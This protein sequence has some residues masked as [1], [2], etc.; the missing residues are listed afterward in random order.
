[1]KKIFS[2]LM[3]V[4]IAA[5][6]FTACED[7]PEPYN[8]PYNN[9]TS[10]GEEPIE[11]VEPAGS[12]TLEDP[13]NVARA[14]ELT[15]AMADGESLANVYV[16]G[17]IV[18]ITDMSTSYGNCTYFISD[19]ERGSNR[20]E[21]YRGYGLNGDYFTTGTEIKEGDLVVVKGTMVN[22][23]G[24]TPELTQGSEI[25]SIN[26]EG[27]GSVIPT[28]TP[29]DYGKGTADAPYN[30]AGVQ[31]AGSGTGVY[32]K[33][34][35]VGNVEGQVLSSGAVFG[36][37]GDTQ[38]NILLADS[39]SETDLSN[40]IPVQLPLGDVRTAVNLKDN[41]GNYKKEVTLY[42]NIEKYF[43][44]TG[45]K[46]VSFAIID[47]KEIGTN[48]NGSTTP[49]PQPSG[50]ARGTGTL[51]DP[52]NAAAANAY[53]ASL[54]AD[55]VSSQN[56]YIKGKIIEITS[57]NQFGVQYG[58]CTFYIS[59]DGTDTAD[60]FYIFRTLYF[61]NVKY[62]EGPLPKAGDEVVICGKVVNFRGNT[63]ETAQ[64]KSYIYS[65][66]GKTTPDDSGSETPAST[67]EKGTLENPFNAAEA[68][69]F[70]AALAADKVTDSNVYIKGKI[71]EITSDNQFGVQYGN[72]TFYISDDGTDTADKFYI[73][74]TLY[75]GNVKYT[76]GPLPEAGDE[77]I[78]CGKVVNF[79]G[80]T[81][82]TAQ[83]KSYIY[84]LNGK[85]SPSRRSTIA[86]V[87]RAE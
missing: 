85:T 33:A 69:A 27:S 57:S 58:N 2:K 32:V 64:D 60:K 52:F 84:S 66:N 25:V 42:G 28:P 81:P 37:T 87:R 43:G 40:C 45:L 41:P 46:S 9:A 14:I 12:G 77:V 3:A 82:E 68:N 31:A 74:R 17:Y 51:E 23:K 78:I 79:R 56:F 59:D 8:N 70:T 18:E 26:G 47:G 83:N 7:V 38:T 65:L 22:F 54:P 11:E 44:A 6:V 61:G 5:F 49:E 75:F 72:C 55:Q 36:S 53:V 1:M 30:V 71:I 48:P 16:K 21:I 76:E 50:E 29:A 67:G 80:N 62:T 35:I 73:F 20:Y 34:Y 15:S 39:P 13:Y 63:P 24:N 19:D 10:G 4:A 86:E